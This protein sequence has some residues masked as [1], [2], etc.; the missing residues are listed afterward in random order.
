M[1]RLPAG[2]ASC[3]TAVIR[4]ALDHRRKRDWNETVPTWTLRG[5][6]VAHAAALLLVA[7]CRARHDE[8]AGAVGA[9]SPRSLKS[10]GRRRRRSRS[11]RAIPRSNAGTSLLVVARFH[12]AVPAEASLVVESTESA[13]GRAAA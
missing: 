2:S 8:P 7:G 12:G 9:A 11:I 6:M 1:R 13:R 3:N 10:A 5:A 4:E